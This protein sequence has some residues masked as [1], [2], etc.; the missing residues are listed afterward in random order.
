MR[1]SRSASRSAA[2]RAANRNRNTVC[3][4]RRRRSSPWWGILF[5]FFM[6]ALII[7]LSYLLAN[8]K[9]QD[10]VTMTTDSGEKLNLTKKQDGQTADTPED[11]P[12]EQKLPEKLDLQA[13][14]ES[15]VNS[16]SGRTSVYIYDLDYR[17]AIAKVGE[18]QNYQTASIYKLFPVYEGYRR[19]EKGDWDK[20][21]ILVGSRTIAQCLDAAIRSSDS[22]CGEALW[23]KIGHANLDE[24]IKTDYKIENS[25]ISSFSS[26]PVDVA[27]ILELY[28]DHPEFSDATYTT[29][30]DSMLN[31]PATDNGMCDPSCV[32]RQGLPASLSSDKIKVYDKVGWD[33]SGSGWNLYHDA[34][35]VTADAEENEH[36]LIVV[37]MTAGISNYTEI[38]NF[39]TKLKAALT[40]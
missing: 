36:H 8:E 9:G 5:I 15:W 4:P 31:Q 21:T 18:T 27:K 33:Y 32:W 39:G 2:R 28:Y 3:R 34:A 35:I 19:I 1:L 24:I 20:D 12:A 30:L 6:L 10:N 37:V 23:S 13:L 17:T 40:K 25:K 14:A 11:A 26:N 16:A 29:I 7:S 22:T 38:T